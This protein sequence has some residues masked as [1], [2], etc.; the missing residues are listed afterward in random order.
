MNILITGGC[1]FIGS[2]LVK[3]LMTY[4]NSRITIIDNL[5]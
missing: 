1:G 3:R 5:C 4:K 2:N